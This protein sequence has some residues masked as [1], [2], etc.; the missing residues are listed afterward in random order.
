MPDDVQIVENSPF[1]KMRNVRF[2]L[3]GPLWTPIAI[4]YWIALQGLADF[5]R[6]FHR[7]FGVVEKYQRYPI[8][9]RQPNQL[10]FRLRFLK[11]GSSTD[12]LIQLREYFGL[13][14]NQ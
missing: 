7:R 9:S 5:H 12:N 14:I 11:M 8:T 10:T 3:I 6:T 1:R 4:E 13:I 2:R